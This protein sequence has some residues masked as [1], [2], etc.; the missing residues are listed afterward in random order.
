MDHDPTPSEKP[1]NLMPSRRVIVPKREPQI[2]ELLICSLPSGQ[3]PNSIS[4]GCVFAKRHRDRRRTSGHGSR[5]RDFSHKAASLHLEATD[6][7]KSETQYVHLAR[8]G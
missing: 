7:N 5:M 6:R 2:S 4:P 1:A 3:N 8:C